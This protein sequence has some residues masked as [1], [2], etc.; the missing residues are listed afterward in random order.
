MTGLGQLDAA[1]R[2][3]GLLSVTSLEIELL[4]DVHRLAKV[5]A[6]CREAERSAH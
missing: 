4:E 5:P 3:S 1:V 2:R 6:R